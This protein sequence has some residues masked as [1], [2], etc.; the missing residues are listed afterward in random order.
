MKNITILILCI[1]NAFAL[2]ASE[3]TMITKTLK[4][5]YDHVYFFKKDRYHHFSY[6]SIERN[7][8]K[9][10]CDSLGVEIIAPIYE[11]LVSSIF[12]KY[13]VENMGKQI[14]F[15][16]KGE[17]LFSESNEIEI[18]R[19]YKDY[20]I[21][22]ANGK[23]KYDSDGIIEK[24]KQNGKWG[25]FSLISKSFVVPCEYEFIGKYGEG[26]FAFCN[27]GKL[28]NLDSDP[29]GGKWGYMD[30]EGKVI[31]DA[32]YDSA[33]RFSDGTAQIRNGKN[34]S[35]IPN[36]L[37]SDG[38]KVTQSIHRNIPKANFTNDNLFVF[39]IGNETY[40]SNI[41]SESSANDAELFHRYSENSLGCPESN[42]HYLIDASYANIR[43]KLSYMREIAEVYDGEAKF[44]IYYSGLGIQDLEGERYLLPIDADFNNLKTT[45]I[46]IGDIIDIFNQIKSKY[47]LAIIDA[48]FNGSDKNNKP[49][50]NDRG[51]SLK[52]KKTTK[53]LRNNSMVW[54][55]AGNN[56]IAFN[57]DNEN[58]SL[59]SNILM[60][61]MNGK[62]NKEEIMPFV[63][64]VN[65]RTKEM[66]LKKGKEI[67]SPILYQSTDYSI[68][69]KQTF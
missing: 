13:I 2:Y 27:G 66:S 22:I 6:Y 15:S 21:C 8:K 56:G 3:D 25:V 34:V 49:F 60:Q 36:P 52:L 29:S 57:S 35:L 69:N 33:E 30:V 10:V 59:F 17:I 5:K 38:K 55:S 62:M 42:I 44:I 14:I 51:V 26:L 20:L 47:S 54:I 61:E 11:D 41:M 24:V 48:S 4:N 7:G 23:F 64:K 28:K 19:Y 50:L 18:A 58:I 53:D 40:A 45:A 67:Q 32:Q 37:T 39:I 1:I 9:G 43:R 65:K 12:D 46:P 16:Q 68:D 63:E 31:I